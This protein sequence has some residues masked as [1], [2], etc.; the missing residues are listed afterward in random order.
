[1]A[2]TYVGYAACAAISFFFVRTVV[3]ETRGRELED[4]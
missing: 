1:L 3:K 4:M 2:P